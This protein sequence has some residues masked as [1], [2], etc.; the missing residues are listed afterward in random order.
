MDRLQTAKQRILKSKLP[1]EEKVRLMESYQEFEKKL[2][3]LQDKKFSIEF[4]PAIF[5]LEIFIL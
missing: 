4:S 2:D 5:L 1:I 3:L